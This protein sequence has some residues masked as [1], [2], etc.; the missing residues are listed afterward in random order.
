MKHGSI[1]RF[2]RNFS[3]VGRPR[4]EVHECYMCGESDV[5]KFPSDA[6]RCNGLS[7]YCFKCAA[8]RS[9]DYQRRKRKILLAA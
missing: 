2:S 3:R 1:S 5:N 8:R 9:R 6:S 7:A 4:R